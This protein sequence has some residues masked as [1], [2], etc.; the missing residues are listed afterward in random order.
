MMLKNVVLPA[1]FGP[2]RLTIERGG[3]AKSMLLT[4]S[5]PPNRLLTRTARRTSPPVETSII[6]GLT[7]RCRAHR[8]DHLALE[9][10]DLRADAELLPPALAREQA[11]R[12]QQHHEHERHA[13]EQV[14]I[15][16][17]VN[18]REDRPDDRQVQ[19]LEESIQRL[20]QRDLDV[21]D[22]EC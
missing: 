9:A 12:P 8:P 5:R 18:R 2:M 21:V 14:L 22:D 16:R 4:A 3:M 17:E 11:F 15:L 13:V 19:R 7:A 1:P 20:E 10:L 6:L